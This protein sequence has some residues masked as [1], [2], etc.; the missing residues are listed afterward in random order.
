MNVGIL[1]S[2]KSLEICGFVDRNVSVDCH[3][4]DDVDRACH[5]GVDQRQLQMSLVEGCGVGFGIQT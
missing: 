5:E 3:E 4:D 2:V 1:G